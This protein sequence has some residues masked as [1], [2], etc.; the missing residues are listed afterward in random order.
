M[1]FEVVSTFENK[2][3]DFFGSKYGVAVDNCTHGLKLYLRY[4]KETRINVPKR[5]YI[6]GPFLA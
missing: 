3:S 6:S 2:R 4:T 1:N 5:T